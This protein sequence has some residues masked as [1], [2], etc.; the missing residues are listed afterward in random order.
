[1][2]PTS[3]LTIIRSQYFLYFAVMGAVL[4]YFNLYCYHIGFS[5]YQIGV[6]SAVRSFAIVLFPIFW[7]MLVDRFRIQKRIYVVCNFLG[8]FV[9]VGYF[10]TTDFGP[11]IVITL[12]YGIFYTPII[13]L[14]ET[15][16]MDVLA[17]D[18]PRYGQTRVW[19]SISFI[20]VVLSLGRIIDSLGVSMILGMVLV[21]SI[22][23]SFLA[24][25]LPPGRN[26][27][28]SVSLAE[29]RT[30]F[31]GRLTL[32]L[33]CAFCMLVS[34]GAYY[35][36]FSIHLE[37]LGFS[38]THIG[39]AWALASMAEILVMVAS[40][41]LFRRYSPKKMMLFSFGVATLRWLI[42]YW[43]IS[44]AIIMLSQ[45]L[46]AIT[47]GVF[48]MASIL[49]VDQLSPKQ[50]KALGQAVNNSVTYGLGL[51]VGFY[52][53]GWLYA[54]VDLFFLFLISAGIAAGGGIILRT[55]VRLPKN[56]V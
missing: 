21:V 7:G 32:F 1:M 49:Y 20:L 38:G 44:P 12:A 11:M 40:A 50:G 27:P 51:M 8:T 15:M 31:T 55:W 34:H 26:R 45:L 41:S 16:T 56:D 46:H 39:M 54:H 53:N 37:N 42:L 36:F 48:H 17:G 3:P 10:F 13:S 22:L 30:L 19:G 33:V 5:G 47:Y 23:Q 9:W 18:K 28:P 29:I 43:S 2:A 4:P 24:T 35:G 52:L 25:A 6:L 14:L